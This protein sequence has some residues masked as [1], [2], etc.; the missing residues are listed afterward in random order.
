[1]STLTSPIRVV[2]T[3]ALLALLSVPLAAHHGWG[4][5]WP[6]EFELT[7]I[8]ETPISLAGPHGSM[9][10]RVERQLW[11]VVLAPPA[12][13]RRA[14]LRPDTIPVGATVTVHG[15]RHR[16][17]NTFEVKTERVTWNGR[18]FNVYP[19]RD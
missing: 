4:G 13:T 17:K 7:G 5:Y 9:R 15:H 3:A 2:A 19:D 18:T 10:I 11:N 6:Q 16:D 8:V 12:R 1:M 14:G